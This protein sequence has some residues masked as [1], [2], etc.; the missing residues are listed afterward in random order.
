MTR[1]MFMSSRILFHNF[2]TLITLFYF[3]VELKIG[4][5]FKWAKPESK[6]KFTTKRKKYFK[7]LLT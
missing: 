4:P 6:I 3:N 1:G 7:S 5:L 2:G